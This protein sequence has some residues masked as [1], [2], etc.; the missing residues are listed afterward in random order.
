MS[1]TSPVM[2][3]G[4]IASPIASVVFRLLII[5]HVLLYGLP[6][7][8]LPAKDL[9]FWGLIAASMTLG[10]LC[11]TPQYQ[12]KKNK[13]EPDWF[14]LVVEPLHYLLGYLFLYIVL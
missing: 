12:K 3:V 6:W 8:G 5:N 7:L 2:T 4:K 13:K 1:E 11:E 14:P 10:F 9:G